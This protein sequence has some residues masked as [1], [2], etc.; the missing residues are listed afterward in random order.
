M[1]SLR[2]LQ[3]VGRVDVTRER[4]LVDAKGTVLSFVL[5]RAASLAALARGSPA[6]LPATAVEPANVPEAEAPS[7]AAHAPALAPRR[8]VEPGVQEVRA[9]TPPVPSASQTPPDQL[10][11]QTSAMVDVGEGATRSPRAS[12]S[13]TSGGRSSGS[14]RSPR[15][16]R[17]PSPLAQATMAADLA[18]G[19]AGTDVAIDP[20]TRDE[21]ETIDVKST[22]P[23]V[24][25]RDESD[26][27]FGLKGSYLDENDGL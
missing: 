19:V 1:Q 2:P 20:Q 16:S 12:P 25:Q 3:T 11:S 7:T 10:A 21:E 5:D 17:G 15:G 18:V 14:V 6:R 26:G 22:E 9:A 13:S 4:D 27:L 8:D 23:A 24:V